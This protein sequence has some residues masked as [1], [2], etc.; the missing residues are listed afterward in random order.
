MS[1][2]SIQEMISA[3][4][5]GEL[6]PSQ[7]DEMFTHLR[8]C[9]TCRGFVRSAVQLRN[10][11]HAAGSPAVPDSLDARVVPLEASAGHHHR[12]AQWNIHRL[13]SYRLAIP[14]PAAIASAIAL[15][16]SLV[17]CSMLLLNQGGLGVAAHQAHITAMPE[18]EVQA[19][20]PP[21]TKNVQ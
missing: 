21:P 2:E 15:I 1:C 8:E 3:F 18:V 14:A 4:L 7:D 11:L 19:I 17:W 20:F 9:R 10:S 5:D 12:I 6:A 16:A 13:F